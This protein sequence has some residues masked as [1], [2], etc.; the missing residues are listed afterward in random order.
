MI[1]KFAELPIFLGNNIIRGLFVGVALIIFVRI[2]SKGKIE[3]DISLKIIRWIVILYCLIALTSWLLLLIFP[4]SEKYAFLDR[5]TGPY[6]WA[7]WL[8]LIM[9]CLAPLILLNK[10]I[11]KKIYVIFIITLLMNIGWI[12]EYFIIFITSIHRDYSNNDYSV[13][14]LHSREITIL[15]KG[16][17]IGLIAL[18]IG[19]GIKK[20]NLTSG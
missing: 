15:T 9:N 18:I 19:N 5:A 16:F 14:W 17:F 20:W 11:S 6:A 2:L 10:N 7:Y 1:D 13:Y 8:M 4:H 12:L 3:T